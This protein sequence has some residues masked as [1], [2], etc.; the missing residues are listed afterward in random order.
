MSN[1]AAWFIV[2]NGKNNQS[3]KTAI[4]WSELSLKIEKNNHYYLHTLAQLY[5]KN[6]EKQKAIATE[7]LAI[8]NNFDDASDY[9]ATL[10]KMKNGTY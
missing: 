6:G 10:K 2:E 7:Q 9:I 1:N 8:E 5:Y 4:K 3:I